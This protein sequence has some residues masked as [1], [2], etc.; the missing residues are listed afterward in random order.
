MEAAFARG[1]DQQS[2]CSRI[3]YQ[4]T[5]QVRAGRLLGCAAPAAPARQALP[6][7]VLS[8]SVGQQAQRIAGGR[9]SAAAGCRGTT[10]P[11]WL[12]CL[13]RLL[14]A[15]SMM[16]TGFV[17]IWLASGAPA[18]TRAAHCDVATAA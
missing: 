9:V 3:R 5:P 7:A 10:H 8:C 17:M 6:S 12:C 16:C 13:Q 4:A 14:Q 15:V 11:I 18:L 1:W 2:V